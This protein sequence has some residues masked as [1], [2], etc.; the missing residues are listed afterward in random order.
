VEELGTKV[1]MAGEGKSFYRDRD[2]WKDITPLPQDDGPNPVVRIAY[3]EKC[4]PGT[5]TD[6]FSL[7]LH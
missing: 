6:K 7:C 2:D 1:K 5:N 4:K 3:S